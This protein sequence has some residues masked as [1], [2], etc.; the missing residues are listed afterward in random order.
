MVA[1]GHT[2]VGTL[3][4]LGVFHYFGST[5]PVNGLVIAGTAGVISH[6]IAD[7]VPHGHL[8]RHDEFK[9][10][11]YLEIIFNLFL[12]IALVLGIIIWKEGLDLK[13]WYVFFGIVGSQLPDVLDGLIYI[14]VLPKKGLLKIENNFH[15]STHWHGAFKNALLW[16]FKRRDIWQVAVGVITLYF[17]TFG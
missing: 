4:G 17:V 1:F 10:K 14:D 9:S 8:L 16:N 7:F 6:Y 2:A 5:D 15:A 11:V 12:S 13:F 3:V